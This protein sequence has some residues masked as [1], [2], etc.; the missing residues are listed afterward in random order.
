MQRGIYPTMLAG[1]GFYDARERQAAHALIECI[2][3]LSNVQ[4]HLDTPTDS[5]EVAGYWAHGAERVPIYVGIGDHQC[6]LLVRA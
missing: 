6:S 3:H 2:E 1:L 5:I 4:I